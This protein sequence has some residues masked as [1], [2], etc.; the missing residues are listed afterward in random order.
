MFKIVK[1]N[2]IIDIIESP[3]YVVHQARNDLLLSTEEPYGQGIVSSDGSMIWQLSGRAALPGEYEAVEII[4][5]SDEEA[6]VYKTILLGEE[7]EEPVSEEPVPEEIYP[8]AVVSD[9][10]ATVQAL[11]NRISNLEEKVIY[12]KLP[13]EFEPKEGL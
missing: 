6:E 9:L 1:D 11:K 4:E 5:I 8:R 2:T 3:C 10:Q 13:N 7:P 12:A